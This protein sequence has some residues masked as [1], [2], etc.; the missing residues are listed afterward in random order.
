MLLLIDIEYGVIRFFVCA[1]MVVVAELI[2]A[3]RLIA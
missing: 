1:L 3:C 2:A